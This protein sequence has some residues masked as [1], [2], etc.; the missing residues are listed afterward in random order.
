MP[1]LILNE[2]PM[3]LLAPANHPRME[4]EKTETNNLFESIL[5]GDVLYSIVVKKEKQGICSKRLQC[6]FYVFL[7]IIFNLHY[8]KKLEAKFF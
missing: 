2:H 4:C 7:Y 3:A 5:N 6:V 8:P 1:Y